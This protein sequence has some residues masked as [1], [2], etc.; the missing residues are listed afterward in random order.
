[1]VDTTNIEKKS[2]EA[3]V[4]LCAERYNALEARLDHV[5]AKITKL[6]GVICE[7]RDLVQQMNSKRNEQLIAW[8]LTTIGVLI[9]IIGFFVVRFV[10]V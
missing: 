2:L 1:M 6:D 4:E 8:G 9:G 10:I 7:V 5:N 3:H